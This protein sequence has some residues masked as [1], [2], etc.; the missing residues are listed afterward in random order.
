MLLRISMRAFAGIVIRNLVF[1]LDDT[2]ADRFMLVRRKIAKYVGKEYTNGGD[3][4]WTFEQEK[5]KMIPSPLIIGE[6]ATDMDKGIFTVEVSEDVKRCNRLQANL[7][8][9]YTSPRTFY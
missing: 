1:D 4:R 2:R 9:L 6:D 8:K 7:E 3:V 5:M